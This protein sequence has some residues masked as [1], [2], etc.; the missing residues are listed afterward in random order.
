[1]GQVHRALK[2]SPGVPL[3]PNFHLF[4]NPES[5]SLKKKLGMKIKY[6]DHSE[7]NYIQTHI[8]IF[9]IY[10]CTLQREIHTFII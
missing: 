1:M 4:T 8:F 3:F 9:Y 10:I 7:E 5:C 2:P 6:S